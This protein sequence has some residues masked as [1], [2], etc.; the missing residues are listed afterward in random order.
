MSVIH[1]IGLNHRTAQVEI[2][3]KFA[4]TEFTSPEKWPFLCHKHCISSV[5]DKLAVKESLIL[6]TCNRV[7]MIVVY[8]G[9]Y[10]DL[11]KVIPKNFW[12]NDMFVYELPNYFNRV[13]GTIKNNIIKMIIM[14]AKIIYVGVIILFS[15]L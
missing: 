8:D 12:N 15:F 9:D 5:Q 7:E 11:L 4:L 1:L 2:R 6:S 10:E 3:E 14:G 13:P